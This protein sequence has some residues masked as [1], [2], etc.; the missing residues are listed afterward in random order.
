ML[1]NGMSDVHVVYMS[2]SVHPIKKS[3]INKHSTWQNCCRL[4]REMNLQRILDADQFKH[5]C[6]GIQLKCTLPVGRM[7]VNY[8]RDMKIYAKNQCRGAKNCQ[9]KRQRWA[10]LLYAFFRDKA[11]QHWQ[12]SWLAV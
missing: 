12:F 8:S 2:L 6:C 4:K 5:L 7:T 3:P 9:K 11:R 10:T 1:I